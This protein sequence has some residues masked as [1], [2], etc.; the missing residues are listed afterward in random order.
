[1]NVM[2][3]LTSALFVRSV[4]AFAPLKTPSLRSSI[5]SA[6]SL[7]SSSTSAA[8][9]AASDSSSDGATAFDYDFVVIGGGSGGVRAS[10]IASSHGARTLLLETQLQHGAPNYSAIGGTCVNVGCVPKKLMVFAARYPA[11]I[12]E[13]AGYGWVGASSGTF[14]WQQFMV[15]KDREIS[16]LNAVYKDVILGRA[17]VEIMEGLGALNGPNTV[18]VQLSNGE[19]RSVTAKNILVATGGWPFKPDIPGAEHTIT[20]NEIFYLKDQPKRIVCVGGGFI[21]A[22]FA[23][24]MDGL[25]SDVTLMYRGDLFLRGFDMDMRQHLKEEMERN[26][27]I[28]LQF[29]TNPAEIVKNSDGTLTVLTEDGSK[30]ECDAVMMATGRKGKIDTLNLESAGVHSANSFIPVNEYSQ[31][32]VANIYAVGDVTDRI[33]LTP[34]ALME[35]HRLADTLFGGMDR[36][37]DHDVVASTVF[38]N[39]EL[40]TCGYTEDEAA[41]KFRDIAVY[42]SKFRAMKHSFPGSE[43]YSL[44]KIIVDSKTDKVVGCH[45]ATDGAGEMIQGVAIAMKMGATKADFDATIGIHPTSAE[46]LVT[47]RTPSYL[48]KDGKKVEQVE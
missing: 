35:G 7:S 8:A 15:Y 47:M 39:P 5:R 25:G 43:V 28:D 31:T 27:N 10:R 24:I 16:R 34:V 29:N 46:E 14:D 1:M 21:A 48:Y 42:K 36:K 40:G 17:G 33:A 32:N 26:T 45:L 19:T 11:E 41:A 20:S 9:A 2:K 18:N 4:T 12:A 13:A 23:S 22:E 38:T 3:F 30:I 44:F 37:V 6:S